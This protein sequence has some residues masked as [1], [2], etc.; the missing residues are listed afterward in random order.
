MIRE[1]SWLGTQRYC[2]RSTAVQVRR[3]VERR[4]RRL[5]LG[6]RAISATAHARLLKR[7]HD[8]RISSR[9]FTSE[10][11]YS[12]SESSWGLSIY[13]ALFT[14]LSRQPLRAHSSAMARKVGAEPAQ[15]RLGWRPGVLLHTTEPGPTSSHPANYCRG[16]RSGTRTC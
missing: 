2:G 10:S 9:D 4:V 7:H 13:G 11:I 14:E 5:L 3:I 12:S 1:S 6:N 16:P 15:R 8:R